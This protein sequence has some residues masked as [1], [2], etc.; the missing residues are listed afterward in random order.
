M[1]AHWSRSPYVA[2]E[3]VAGTVYVLDLSD[4]RRPAV[5]VALEGPGTSIWLMLGTP[6]EPRPLAAIVESLAQEYDVP[7]EDLEA[8]VL[9]FLTQLE[10][11]GF[12][13]RVPGRNGSSQP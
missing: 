13:V 7:P 9:N 3:H 11:Q 5:P 1:S 6:H 8:D 2:F 12:V 10:G 4:P